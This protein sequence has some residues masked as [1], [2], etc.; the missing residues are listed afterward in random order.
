MEEKEIRVKKQFGNYV[1]CVYS[2]GSASVR[3]VA[4]NWE[5]RHGADS[6]VSVML[7]ELIDDAGMED[8]FGALFH[9]HYVTTN[10]M[11]DLEFMGEFAKAYDAYTKREVARMEAATEVYDKEALEDVRRGIEA[12]ER[13]RKAEDDAKVA[14]DGDDGGKEG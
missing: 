8:Y 5:L 7:S 6:M 12:R 2:D 11:L 4:G 10:A 9:V 13:M 3:S 1:A 14:G